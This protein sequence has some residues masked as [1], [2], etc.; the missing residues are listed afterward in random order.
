MTD[1]ALST[2]AFVILVLLVVLVT[3]LLYALVKNQW[4]RRW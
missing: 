4:G 2:A 3:V 1:T